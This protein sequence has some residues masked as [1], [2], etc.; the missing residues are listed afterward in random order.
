MGL[1]FAAILTQ[2]FI[3]TAIYD[4]IETNAFQSSYDRVQERK[5]QQLEWDLQQAER[6]VKVSE[7]TQ[8]SSTIVTG[9]KNVLPWIFG[10]GGICICMVIIST[11]KVVVKISDAAANKAILVARQIPMD[12]ETGSYPLLLSEDGKYL[13]DINSYASMEIGKEYAPQL[14]FVDRSNRVRRLTIIGYS[15]S[16]KN[17][18]GE[19]ILPA[20]QENYD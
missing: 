14:E 5:Q 15:T 6:A 2:S 11:T 13:L 10:I 4:A 20:L 17:G 3:G 18:G 7:R 9:W 19:V 8:I 1:A 12:P 16:H